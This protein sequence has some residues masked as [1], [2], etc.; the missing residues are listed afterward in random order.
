MTNKLAHFE[1]YSVAPGAS[2]DYYG[3]KVLNNEVR[4]INGEIPHN[5]RNFN[6]RKKSF[7]F[8]LLGYLKF[9]ESFLWTSFTA[10]RAN[11]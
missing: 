8:S 7:H 3:L 10:G 6:M 1:K 4:S 5:L 2:R 9:V 11:N